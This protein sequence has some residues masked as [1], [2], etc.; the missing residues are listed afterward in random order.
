MIETSAKQVRLAGFQLNSLISFDESGMS[1]RFV[2]SETQA[3]GELR[4]D[5]SV[6]IDRPFLFFV[7]ESSTNT[8]LRIGVI[9]DPR[10]QESN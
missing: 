10:S 1:S 8:V 5:R 3:S 2:E 6:V 9:Q 4:T 7:T